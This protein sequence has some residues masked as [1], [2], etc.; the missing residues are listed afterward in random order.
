MLPTGTGAGSTHGSLPAWVGA[1][2]L[3]WAGTAPRPSLRSHRAA[4]VRVDFVAW[5]NPGPQMP[6]GMTQG[7]LPRDIHLWFN[8]SHN[9]TSRFSTGA[10]GHFPSLFCRL[11]RAGKIPSCRRHSGKHP[12]PSSACHFPH[13]KHRGQTQSPSAPRRSLAAIVAGSEGKRFLGLP[14]TARLPCCDSVLPASG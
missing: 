2:C 1:V 3:P 8:I 7:R 11:S 9:I 4:P 5:P 13:L 14:G 6:P 12:A 10:R